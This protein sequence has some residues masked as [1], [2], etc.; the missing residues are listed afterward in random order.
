MKKH[1]VGALLVGLF[2]AG[3]AGAS[4]AGGGG[5]TD[6][7]TCKDG[8]PVFVN[9][10]CWHRYTDYT[11][12]LAVMAKKHRGRYP[13]GAPDVVQTI[14]V[15]STP[16]T[17]IIPPPVSDSSAEIDSA[18]YL[19]DYVT[20]ATTVPGPLMTAAVDGLCTGRAPSTVACMAITDSVTAQNDCLQQKA[21][22]LTS[23]GT[24][25]AARAVG[26]SP[27]VNLPG[28]ASGTIASGTT[29][30]R[31]M[32]DIGQTMRAISAVD[33]NWTTVNAG[34]FS[35]TVADVQPLAYYLASQGFTIAP[36]GTWGDVMTQV[37][38]CDIR[39]SCRPP[40]GPTCLTTP[41]VMSNATATTLEGMGVSYAAS[42]AEGALVTRIAVAEC[43]AIRAVPGLP[44]FNEALNA[45]KAAQPFSG[46]DCSVVVPPSTV[47]DCQRAQAQ[48]SVTLANR[49]FQQIA[50]AR[51]YYNNSETACSGYLTA[52][53]L[54][55]FGTEQWRQLDQLKTLFACHILL[56]IPSPVTPIKTR[57][58]TD[59]TLAK[60][61]CVVQLAVCANYC[62]VPQHCPA[63]TGG[64]NTTP[65]YGTVPTAVAAGATVSNEVRTFCLYP[66]SGLCACS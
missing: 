35:G 43:E 8:K 40:G 65:A 14:R 45:V 56:P 32:Y 2:L 24:L 52:L 15:G 42:A 11:Y 34:G 20:L 62:G 1:A 63:I 19:S 3:C 60:N 13:G 51:G 10:G 6:A 30:E 37:A 5:G 57:T 64:W 22:C 18:I 4:W 46:G 25:A 29:F 39:P 61:Q 33:A 59:A 38:L 27:A 9:D 50:F 55:A 36:A 28:G 21:N 16:S 31:M 26:T 54:S 7:A 41:A 12:A 17:E 66:E 49:T 58:A 53:S 48:W 47:A 23:F 44:L